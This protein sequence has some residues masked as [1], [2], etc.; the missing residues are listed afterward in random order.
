LGSS[1]TVSLSL[2][3]RILG[4][5]AGFLGGGALGIIALVGVMIFAR[6]DFGLESIRPGALV[7]AV[8][9]AIVGF[10]S[11]KRALKALGKTLEA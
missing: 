4:A 7:G 5:L 8:L 6:S 11:P 1:V 2:I 10:I 3:K 9:G